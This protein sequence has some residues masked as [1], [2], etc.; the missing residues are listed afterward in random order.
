M[1]RINNEMWKVSNTKWFKISDSLINAEPHEDLLAV[2]KD[3]VARL[4]EDVRLVAA[5]RLKSTKIDIPGLVEIR[6]ARFDEKIRVL[7]QKRNLSGIQGYGSVG[8][9]SIE[10]IPHRASDYL[11]KNA[12]TL[13]NEIPNKRNYRVTRNGPIV[14]NPTTSKAWQ[15]REIP[16]PSKQYG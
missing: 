4:D 11:K 9:Y 16:D 1:R 13:L 5:H 3:L 10:L 6:F 8:F 7:R 15:I 12:K 2:A 14:K